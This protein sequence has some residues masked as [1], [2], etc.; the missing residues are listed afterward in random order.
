MSAFFLSQWIQNQRRRMREI[1]RGQMD[2]H[3]KSF[4]GK[5]YVFLSDTILAFHVLLTILDAVYL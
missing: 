5:I 3:R 4:C 2:R 1:E